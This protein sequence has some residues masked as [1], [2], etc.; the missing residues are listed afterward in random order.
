MRSPIQTRLE[1]LPQALPVFP[2]P[3]AVLLPWGRMPLNIFET[4]YLHMTL[5]DLTAGR[6]FGMIQPQGPAPK[7]EPGATVKAL[8]S[9][10]YS[11]G[12]AGRVASFEET[13]D[14]RLMISL[15]GLIRF[16][17]VEELEGRK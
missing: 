11:V 7:P 15:K 6:I 16:R 12:C 17:V 10:L 8:A 13:E 4:R 5:D 3:S 2:L 14:G 1:D 9:P